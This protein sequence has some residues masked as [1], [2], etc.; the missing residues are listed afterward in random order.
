LT[1]GEDEQFEVKVSDI[2]TLYRTACV[3]AGQGERTVSRDELTGVQA[4]ERKH[5]NLPLAPGQVERREFEYIRHGTATF[6]LS[7]DGLMCC[8]DISLACRSGSA[9]AVDPRPSGQRTRRAD[10]WADAG[11]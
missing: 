9:S 3:R 1:P 4:L 11:A 7:R 6:I 8:D 5:P 2:C 10:G